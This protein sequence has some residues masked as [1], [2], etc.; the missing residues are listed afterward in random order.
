[1]V[2]K[3]IAFLV[4]A[5]SSVLC[6]V[7]ACKSGSSPVYP[8]GGKLSVRVLLPRAADILPGGAPVSVLLRAASADGVVVRSGFRLDPG[9][10]VP[11]AVLIVPRPGIYVVSAEWINLQEVP[12]FDQVLIGAERVNVRGEVEVKLDLGQLSSYCYEGYLNGFVNTN[13]NF[14]LGVQ[15]TNDPDVLFEHDGVEGTQDMLSGR[16]GV[17]IR[18]L[19]KGDLV[20]VPQLS[21]EGPWYSSAMAAKGTTLAGLESGDLYG[22]RIPDRNARVWMLVTT[23]QSSY[24]V[25]DVYFRFRQNARGEDIYKF[26]MTSYGRVNCNESFVMPD[27]PAYVRDYYGPG[28]VGFVTD[29]VNFYQT[30]SATGR[31]FVVDAAGNT[32][33]GAFG[34]A[35]ISQPR[36]IA[37]NSAGTTL[38]VSEGSCGCV[39]GFLPD[40][41]LVLTI[42]G[43][44]PTSLLIPQ[45]LD[46]GYGNRIYVADQGDSK[47]KV[48]DAATGAGV[49]AFGGLGTNPGLFA[50]PMG[51]A[52]DPSGSL[53]VADTYN[54]RIQKFNASF[55]HVLTFGTY[56]SY[57]GQLYEPWDLAVSPEG[58]RV[59][60][61]DTGNGRV[62]EFDPNGNFLTAWGYYYS[63][64]QYPYAFNNPQRLNVDPTGR[65]FVSDTGNGHVQEFDNLF[66]PSPTATPG[67]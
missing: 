47:V 21:D 12:P 13:F 53:Y 2:R 27:A 34:G 63:G 36:D 7:A 3:R 28:P 26:D 39:R 64:G 44:G 54:H 5:V 45:G 55:Q 8:N 37:L 46:W 6:G 48:F 30:D 59:Y 32:T 23:V 22:I 18:Y 24:T 41:T 4:L 61:L 42:T 17:S 29:G 52:A 62:Q 67:F 50:E 20:D 33:N 10:A 16:A 60:V 35:A 31:I 65:I 57:N 14:D 58:N 38:Y 56:G 40:G 1:M 19:G 15:D 51:V 66:H 9:Y 49:T 11:A 25:A 43:S